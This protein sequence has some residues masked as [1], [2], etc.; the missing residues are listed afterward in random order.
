MENKYGL[1]INIAKEDEKYFHIYYNDN[2]K[3]EIKSALIKE[4]NKVSKINIIIGYQIKSLYGLFY[5]CSCI[6]SICFK[7]LSR[8]DITDMS[9]MFYECSSLK[10]LNLNNFD[11]SK[12]TNMSNMFSKCS[13]LKELNLSNF[14]T[15]NVTNM[16]SMFNGCDKLKGNVTTNDERIKSDYGEFIKED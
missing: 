13:S 15:D 3:E 8:N 14:N 1:F 2:K 6:E 11:T 7:Q 4:N 12:V 5:D 10:E 16:N 9:Y